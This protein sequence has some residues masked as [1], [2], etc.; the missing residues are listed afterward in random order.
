MSGFIDFTNCRRIVDKAYNGAN[1]KK[2]AVE[3]EG[4]QYMLKFPPS[5]Q[6][7]PTELSYTNGCFS[8]HIAC[9]IFNMLGVAAQETI[10]G[11]F[12]VAGKAKIV[13]AC[14]DFTIDGKQLFDFC[15]IK[16]TILDSDSNGSGTELSDI[17]ET[18]EKQQFVEPGRLLE[19]FWEVFVIDALLGNFDRHNGNWG[20]L[21]N[22][23]SKSTDLAPVYDCGS[24][25]LPQADESV[26]RS[27]LENE[28]ALN[29]RVF[30]F[31]T[32]AVKLD[33]RKI[34][35]YDFLT[36]AGNA[37]CNKAVKRIFDRLDMKKIHQFIEETLYIS[38]LQKAFYKK[39]IGARISLI[40]APAHEMILADE[41]GAD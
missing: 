19:H 12:D 11:T 16:N 10:L 37:D 40:L 1:G 15:S 24:C 14:R 29:K 31:P 7:K 38:E 32:S 36:K 33:G 6:S 2:I 25:L 4:R 20:F 9:S 17:L 13:C 41:P 35:Y 23:V 3:Y 34:N 39:Y 18:I 26:M 30:Q 22:P 27:V 21:Y 8:E 28:D 5:G